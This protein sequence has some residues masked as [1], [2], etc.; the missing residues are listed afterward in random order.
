MRTWVYVGIFSVVGL[1]GGMGFVF[2]YVISPNKEELQLEN[3]SIVIEEQVTEQ[4]NF[5]ATTTLIPPAVILENQDDVQEPL[6]QEDDVQVLEELSVIE[7]PVVDSKSD[8]TIAQEDIVQEVVSEPQISTLG[9]PVIEP[10]DL[11]QKALSAGVSIYCKNDEGLGGA[12]GSGTV[13]TSD[14]H[15]LTAAHVVSAFNL[16]D[17][18]VM[19]QYDQFSQGVYDFAYAE[20]IFIPS[21][22]NP[23][24]GGE[25]KK[26]NIRDF[27]LL[28]VS[29]QID[30]FTPLPKTFVYIPVNYDYIPEVEER[31]YSVS[32]P[33]E[34]SPSLKDINLV[35]GDNIGVIDHYYVE[36]ENVSEAIRVGDNVASRK[37]ASGGSIINRFGEVIGIVIQKG[38]PIYE[39]G[40]NLL[41]TE[42]EIVN[43]TSYLKKVL[44]DELGRIF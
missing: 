41:I 1:I 11:Y 18:C 27:A 42:T 6:P 38:K 28:K 25:S 36:T 34:T 7:L 9:N 10:S 12:V 22:W 29:R 16:G 14:G 4:E 8:D 19:R 5:F 39:E 13:I 44:E 17:E 2:L 33:A 23:P 32:F 3:V 40:T 21:V 20:I 15:I 26:V 35:F 30:E 37:G 31:V 43:L 24:S